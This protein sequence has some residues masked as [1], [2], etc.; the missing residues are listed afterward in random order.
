VQR[1]AAIAGE[2]GWFFCNIPAFGHDAIFG[3]VFP[4][5]IADWEEDA[6]SGRPF[7]TIHVD[8]RGYPIHGHLTWAD[9]SW[10]VT[11]FESVGLRRELEVERALHLKYDHYMERRSPARRAYFVFSKRASA[12]AQRA[13][14]QRIASEPSKVLAAAG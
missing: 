12:A 2:G 5:Y 4:R 13:V 8:D 7:S 3:T 1:L 14:V 11:R 10:W 9:A 6:R